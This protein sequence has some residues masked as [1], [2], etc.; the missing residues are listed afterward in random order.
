M[1]AQ[2]ANSRSDRV[3][4]IWESTLPACLPLG[5]DA[6]SAAGSL[7]V[8]VAAR[9]SRTSAAAGPAPDPVRS[10]TA[11]NPAA[12]PTYPSEPHSRTGP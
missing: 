5:S 6:P 2:P 1:S 4:R 12:A 10:S 11:P 9:S 3:S 7:Q 8:A